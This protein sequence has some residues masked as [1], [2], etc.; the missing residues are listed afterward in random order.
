MPVGATVKNAAG[1]QSYACQIPGANERRRWGAK[2][3][4]FHTFSGAVLAGLV[5]G[6]SFLPTA[7]LAR[8]EEAMSEEDTNTNAEDA[9]AKALETM[10]FES[11][12]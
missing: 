2:G 5:Y 1:P 12:E 11:S 9:L 8:D 3:N 4:A 7:T 10:K 6:L